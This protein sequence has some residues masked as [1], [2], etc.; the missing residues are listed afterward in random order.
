MASV[1]KLANGTYQARWRPIPN[2]PQKARNFRRKGDAERYLTTV[3]HS[4]LTG[5]YT[6]PHAGKITVGEHGEAWLARKAKTLR[7]TGWETQ[8][9]NFRVHVEPEFGAIPLRQVARPH[10]RAWSESL[11]PPLAPSS[12]KQVLHTFKAIMNDAVDSELIARN[13][14]D[15]ITIG[16]TPD[17]RA[18]PM[19]IAM[20][21]NGET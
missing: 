15:R 19:A 14:A 1:T 13:P 20:S 6:D 2:G 9:S 5:A 17:R 3:E 16:S 10:V 4:L 11:S 8:R 18:D 7:V 21:M 12:A